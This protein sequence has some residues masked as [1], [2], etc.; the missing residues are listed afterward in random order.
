MNW[1]AHRRDPKAMRL[2]I[3]PTAGRY[4]YVRRRW[5]VLFTV[6][7]V[8]GAWLMRVAQWLSQRS[9]AAGESPADPRSILLVQL[10]HLGDAL[11]TTAILPALRS[12]YPQA[13]IEVLAA[14]WNKEVFEAS[15]EVDRVHV[16]RLNRFGR[17]A[18]FGWMLAMVWWG[19]KLRQRRYDLAMDVR[20]EF[21]LALLIWLT[22]AKQ[23]VG[24]E[25]GG[26]GFLL[27]HSAEHVPGRHEVESRWALLKTLGIERPKDE[28]GAGPHYE[29]SEAARARIRWQLP[30]RTASSQHEIILHIGAGTSAKRWPQEHWRRLLGQMVVGLNSRVI[31]VGGKGEQETA[32]KITDGLP[33]PNVLNWTGRL[34]LNELAATIQ[35]ADL[36]VGA[37]SG[38]AHLAAAIGT[39]AIVLFSGTNDPG[40]WRPWGSQVAVLR[41]EVA[42]SPCHRTKCPLAN[43]PCLRELAPQRVYDKIIA[44]LESTAGESL[45]PALP[46]AVAKLARAWG[47]N[48][49]VAIP[50]TIPT[51]WRP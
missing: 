24:W 45:A 43:H 9:E 10:D 50:T 3:S 2:R 8:V 17:A 33:W 16:S 5:H 20:G 48:N 49:E 13:C 32:R 12:R 18:R 28:K 46:A 29:P 34:N 30:P 44:M 39:P 19:L 35:R 27:T 26:G 23:R 38:P 6:V 15:P 7:D 25:C 1:F 42:C 22:G 31:L 14:P 51:V 4:R 47:H 41:H 40:Q 11:L 36:F 21:P 37:D